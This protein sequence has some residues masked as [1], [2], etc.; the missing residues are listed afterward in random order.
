MYVMADVWH[1]SYH[2][3]RVVAHVLRVARGEAYAHV[4]HGLGHHAQQC[5]E[6]HFLA[7]V[8]AFAVVTLAVY[9][10]IFTF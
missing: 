3:Q 9:F 2:A 7:L 10:F 5:R 4:G 8:V 1:L 6:R